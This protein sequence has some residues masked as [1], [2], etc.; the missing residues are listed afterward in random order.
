[1]NDEN[2]WACGGRLIRS[3]RAIIELSPGLE[4]EEKSKQSRSHTHKRISLEIS[5]SARRNMINTASWKRGA[6]RRQ[7]EENEGGSI[8]ESIGGGC[9][10]CGQRGLHR[11]RL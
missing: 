5:I 8:T 6:M 3:V 1:M 7:K 2:D 11:Q 9:C 4:V 10:G